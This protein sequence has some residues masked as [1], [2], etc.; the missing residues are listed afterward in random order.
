MRGAYHTAP[1][2]SRVGDE[3]SAWES[4]DEFFGLTPRAGG[5]LAVRVD[6]NLR[7]RK[8]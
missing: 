4:P 1:P 7:L 2:M 3:L 5:V 6:Q 8:R